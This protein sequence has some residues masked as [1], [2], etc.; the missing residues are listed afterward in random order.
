[1]SSDKASKNKT[2]VSVSN[3]VSKLKWSRAR[4]KSVESCLKVAGY[5]F[6]IGFTF[7]KLVFNAH[8]FVFS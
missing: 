8:F 5:R 6:S 7:V 1:M 4:P 3:I 2:G